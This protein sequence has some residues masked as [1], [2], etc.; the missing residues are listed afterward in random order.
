MHIYLFSPI[1]YSFL[2]Q[3]PQKLADQFVALG[4]PVTFIEPCGLSEYFAGRAKGLPLLIFRSILYELFGLIAF[5]FPFV[6]RKPRPQ[7]G[8]P[9]TGLRRVGMPI[10]LPNNR[11]D[12]ALLERFNASVYRQTLIHR[13]FKKMGEA[14]ESVAIVENPLWGQVLRTGDFT[15]VAY[16]CIDDITLFSGRG[17]AARTEGYEKTLIRMSRALFVTAEKL[18]EGLK[19][20]APGA[21]IS[22]VPNGVDYEFFQTRAGSGDMPE[23][24]E[25]INR[26]ILGYV[27]VLRD[28]MDYDLIEHLAKELP[29]ISIV[30]VGPLDFEFRI[31]RLKSLPN[32]RFP[33]RQ[34]Y[35]DIPAWINAFDVCMIPFLTGPV[36]STTNPV[37]IFEYFALG[38]PVVSTP[39]YELNPF[40]AQGLLTI[41]GGKKAFVEA[42]RE[43]LREKDSA[44]AERRREVA[45]KHSWKLLAESML[46]GLNG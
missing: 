24:L 33:G 3:R 4:H 21:S 7:G 36:S 30:I 18:E 2:H 42:V 19:S 29:D 40:K 32:V 34:E 23:W 38:K 15:R 5:L 46:G 12:S 28:W 44:L 27:G 37:K 31:E 43:A 16:D 25:G 39:L 22:R 6:N 10:I 11:V 41:A 1:P 35:R 26:P 45:R 20:K 17:S 13:V 14:E 9:E 8:A